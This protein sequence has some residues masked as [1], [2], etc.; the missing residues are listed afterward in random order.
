MKKIF[1]IIFFGSLLFPLISL[2]G[3]YQAV[4]NTIIYD[5]LV[6]CGKEV[7]LL[8]GL[9]EDNIE[10]IEEIEKKKREYKK[11]YDP[12]T[13][14]QM[15]C[16]EKNGTWRLVHCQFCHFFVM[17]DGILDFVFFTLVPPIAVLMVVI[18]GVMFFAA[19]GNPG[20]VTGAKKLLTSVVFG[21]II[22]YGAWLLINS[23]FSIIGLSEFAL[24]KI[25]PQGWFFVNCPIEL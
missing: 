23:F 5:G 16:T 11:I 25:W 10:K 13:A 21:L 19:A 4:E 9:P 2:A 14:F 24:E 6:P 15:A 8:P 1:L 20:M 18:G 7:C 12:V 3:V 22:I 17:F